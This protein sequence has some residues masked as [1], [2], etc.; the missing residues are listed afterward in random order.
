MHCWKTINVRK[1]YGLGRLFLLSTLV[2][3]MVFSFAYALLG[4][5]NNSH[6]S[7]DYFL[8][9][10]LAVLGVYPLHKLF[11]FIPMFSH[12]DKIKFIVINQFKFIP[13]LHLRIIEPIQKS[14][15]LFILLAPFIFVNV[16]LVIGALAIPSF[17]HYFTILFAY[18]CGICLIDLVYVKHLSKSP[19]SAFIEETD[20]G[21]EILIAEPNY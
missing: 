7:D 15:F 16:L 8:I 11:H 20:A 1:Q 13:I 6:K 17:A 5:I 21:Y 19:K 14:R 2:V 4:I 9:F 12:R 18:H 3:M 10:M